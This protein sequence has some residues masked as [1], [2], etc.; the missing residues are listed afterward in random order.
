MTRTSNEPERF[1][2]V[3]MSENDALHLLDVFDTRESVRLCD[4][5]SGQGSPLVRFMAK[6]WVHGH[7]KT[8]AVAIEINRTR[9][10]L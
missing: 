9:G 2:P 10:L 5:N 7:G 4:R 6:K 1:A 8:G 3:T